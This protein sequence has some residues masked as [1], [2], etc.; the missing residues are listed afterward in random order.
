MQTYFALTIDL[1]LDSDSFYTYIQHFSCERSNY[2][3]NN[4]LI[5]HVKQLNKI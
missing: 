4:V 1:F 5:L 3:N 2:R